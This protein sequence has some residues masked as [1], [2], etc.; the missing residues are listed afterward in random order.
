MEQIGGVLTAIGGLLLAIIGIIQLLPDY[1]V[2]DWFF[3]IT[4][5]ILGVGLIFMTLRSMRPE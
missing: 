2:L 4:F 5:L 1:V 3:G